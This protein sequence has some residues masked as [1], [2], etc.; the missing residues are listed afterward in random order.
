[1]KTIELLELYKSEILENLNEHACM[2]KLIGTSGEHGGVDE[3]PRYYNVKGYDKEKNIIKFRSTQK[4]TLGFDI[5]IKP[6]HRENPFFWE[7]LKLDNQ[8]VWQWFKEVRTEFLKE[9]HPTISTI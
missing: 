2:F 6:E 1:M 4:S 5:F 9:Y 8:T 7:R 3:T